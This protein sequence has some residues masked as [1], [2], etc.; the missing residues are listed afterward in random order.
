MPPN[1]KSSISYEVDG[2]EW[3]NNLMRNPVS[4]VYQTSN[5]QEIYKR[6]YESKPFFVSVMNPNG[7]IVGQL[8]GVIHKKQFW[9]DTNSISSF[10]GRK[11]NLRTTLNWFHGPII[12]EY[13]NQKEIIFEIFSC[14]DKI[15]K[16][17]KVTMIKGIFP[18]LDQKLLND[19]TDSFNYTTTPWASYITNLQQKPKIL[20]DSFNKKT[21]YD[22]RK[23]ERQ[24]LKFEIAKD[25][26]SYEEFGDIKFEVKKTAGQK[27]KKNP[28]FFDMHRELLYK[29]GYEK[30]FLVKHNGEIIGGI[31]GVIFNGNIIQHG[32]GNASTDP[33]GGPFLTWNALKWAISEKY[34]TFDMGGINPNPKSTKEEKIDFYKSKWGGRKYNYA[35]CTKIFN[36]TKSK[37]S[38]FLK[39]PKRVSKKLIGNI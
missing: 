6:A 38:S 36:K 2:N 13:D 26:K 12:H 16:E 29:N 35:L 34:S 18:S 25:K 14:I 27:F 19:T 5:W 1:L 17:K 32:V 33:I 30:L 9:E 8:G 21:R 20:Y 28:V 15:S 37:I 24:E 22:I 7:K 39:N 23:A 3:N 4:T 11:F 10:F 31:L